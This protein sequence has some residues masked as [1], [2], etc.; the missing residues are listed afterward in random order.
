M[1]SIDISGILAFFSTPIGGNGTITVGVI[2]IVVV[3]MF[4]MLKDKGK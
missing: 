1:V 2:A 3:I 4:M